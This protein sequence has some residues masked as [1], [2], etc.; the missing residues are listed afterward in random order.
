MCYDISFSSSIETI[1]EYFPDLIYDT[2][3]DLDFSN[4]VHLM[5]NYVFPDYPIIY[6]N[7]QDKKLHLNIM[8]WGV[9]TYF[10]KGDLEKQLLKYPDDKVK[11]HKE[12][13]KG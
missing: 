5:G 7:Q 4:A 11:A 10:A 13:E 2:Q 1:Q 9:I 6:R 8:G 3:I 12:F